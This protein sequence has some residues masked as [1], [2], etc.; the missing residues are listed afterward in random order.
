MAISPELTRFANEEAFRDLFLVPLFL[1]FGFSVHNYHGTREYGKDLLLGKIDEF[2]HRL[3][4]G[5]QAKFEESIGQGQVGD[6]LNDVREA[7]DNP[8]RHPQDGTEQRIARFYVVNGGSVSDQAREN[9]FNGIHEPARRANT[10][11]FDG[12]TLLYLD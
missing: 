5:V 6:L 9:F 3:Y 8:F 12:K 7:F 4:Y 11:L 2:G 1:R 10:N